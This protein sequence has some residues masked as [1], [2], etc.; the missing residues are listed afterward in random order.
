M[1]R[2]RLTAARTVT[3]R[4][5]ERGDVPGLILITGMTVALANVRLGHRFCRYRPAQ[6]VQLPDD[7]GVARAALSQDLVEAG[8]ACGARKR[9]HAARRYSWRRPPSRSRR[10]TAPR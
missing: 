2:F 4:S 9:V 6:P 7:Q 8:R 10:C 5:P 3:P 1:R